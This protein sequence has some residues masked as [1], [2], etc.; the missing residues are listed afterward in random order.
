MKRLVVVGLL[1]TFAACASQPPPA[2]P[3]VTTGSAC[4]GG[5]SGFVPAGYSC[6]QSETDEF[7]GSSI[8][9][10]KWGLS[11]TPTCAEGGGYLTLSMTNNST[12]GVWSKFTLPS[13]PAYIEWRR[14]LNPYQTPSSLYQFWTCYSTSTF[15]G[16]CIFGHTGNSGIS[17]ETD[18]DMGD[19]CS[20]TM[21][22]GATNFYSLCTDLWGWQNRSPTIANFVNFSYSGPTIGNGNAFHVIG[23]QRL[24]TPAPNG[25][26]IWSVDG[27]VVKTMGAA[28][29]YTSCGQSVPNYPSIPGTYWTN[30][31]SG[32]AGG[33]DRFIVELFCK[34]SSCPGMSIDWDY[35]RVYCVSGQSC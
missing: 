4:P 10:T 7:N 29:A 3:P 33:L 12:C 11:G 17:E 25:S 26:L 9:S 1:L 16:D 13:A 20:N 8:D 6:L 35:V 19:Q 32:G 34:T 24:P 23:L 18:A 31:P 21:D 27:C 15:N 28:S 22:P 5:D 14:R 30:P 2:P